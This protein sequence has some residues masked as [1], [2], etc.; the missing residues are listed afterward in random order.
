MRKGQ[1]G[2]KFRFSKAKK[3]VDQFAPYNVLDCDLTKPSYNATLF[4]FPMRLLGHKSKLSQRSHSADSIRKL[5]ESFKADAHLIL[6]FLKSVISIQ[7]LEWNPGDSKPH[8]TFRVEITDSTKD[9]VLHTRKKI[10]HRIKSGEMSIQETFTA[11]ITCCTNQ[12][13]VA[14]QK[15]TVLHHIC[16]KHPEVQRLSEQLKQLPWVGLAFPL[17][18][19]TKQAS[20]LGRIFCFLPLPPGDDEDSNTGFPVHV[21]GSFS[22]ADNRRSLKWPSEDRETDASANWNYL[23]LQHV[24]S[25]A[26]AELIKYLVANHAKE[27]DVEDRDRDAHDVY[28]AWPTLSR[29]KFRW[30][31]MVIPSFLKSLSIES[32]LWT[33]ANGGKWVDSS[34]SAVCESAWLHAESRVLQAMIDLNECVVCLPPNVWECLRNVCTDL[35]LMNPQFVRTALKRNDLYVKFNREQ[36]LHLL[37]Y[38]VK[39]AEKDTDYADLDGLKLLP[40]RNGAFTVFALKSRKVQPIFI[41]SPKCSQDL[42]PNLKDRFL[43]TSID[44][45]LNRSLSSVSCCAAVQLEL[46]KP[47]RVCEL[48]KKILPPSSEENCDGEIVAKKS[49]QPN[50]DWFDNIWKWLINQQDNWLSI[51]V[52]CHLIPFENYSKLAQIPLR[53][54][55]IFSSHPESRKISISDNL[56]HGLRKQGCFVLQNC[57]PYVYSSR[58]LLDYI[59]TPDKVLSCI[60]NSNSIS[61]KS[62]DWSQDQ[63]KELV[64]LIGKVVRSNPPD[65]KSSEALTVLPLFRSFKLAIPK[66]L[67]DCQEFAP[68]DLDVRLPLQSDLLLSPNLNEQNILEAVPPSCKYKDLSFAEVFRKAVF[69]TFEG[70][71]YSDKLF[72]IKYLLKHKDQ[73]DKEMRQQMKSLTFVSVGDG[74]LRRPD[75]VFDSKEST[76]VSLFSGKS[77]F[78][79]GD[80]ASDAPLGKDLKEVVGFR[81]VSSITAEELVAVGKEAAAGSIS[82]GRA[83]LRLFA[84]EKW[85]K[86]QLK[87]AK[88]DL[89]RLQ[90]CPVESKAPYGYPSV[91]PWKAAGKETTCQTSEIVCLPKEANVPCEILSLIVGSKARIVKADAGKEF[92]NETHLL[93]GFKVPSPDEVCEHWVEATK[94][95]GRARRSRIQFDTM[96][97]ALFSAL[98]SMI[99]HCWA[100]NAFQNAFRKYFCEGDKFLWIDSKVGFVRSSQIAKSSCFENSLEPW[101]FRVSSA[102]CS[103]LKQLTADLNIKDKFDTSDILDALLE[104]KEF[105]DQ[106]P[107]DAN[108]EDDLSLV[109][110]ILNWVVAKREDL[111]S[112]LR[113]K[114]FVPVEGPLLKLKSCEDLVYCDA[115]W[116]SSSRRELQ[117]KHSFVH[118]EI[119]PETARKL[120]VHSLSELVAKSEPLLFEPCGQHE[121]LTLRLR[122]IIDE[123]KDGLG[124]FKELIQNADDAQAKRICF[125]VDLRHGKTSSL[126]SRGMK[127]CQGPALWAYNDAAFNDEDFI[128]ITK[129]AGRTKQVQLDKIGKFG[130]GFNSVYHVTEVPS[131]VSRNYVVIFDPH[132][133]YLGADLIQDP[134]QPGIKIDFLKSQAVETFEDQFRPYDKVFGCDMKGKTPFPGTL[135]RL[136]LRTRHQAESS[137][138]KNEPC[139]A[140]QIDNAIGELKRQASEVM[141]FLNHVQSI[142]VYKLPEKARSP[143]KLV[144]QFKVTSE[145]SS[146]SGSVISQFELLKESAVVAAATEKKSRD[147]IISRNYSAIKSVTVS[148]KI[149]ETHRWLVCSAVGQNAALS[150]SQSPRGREFGAVPFAGVAAKLGESTDTPQNIRGEVFSFL[151][152][153]VASNLPFHVNGVFSVSSNRR[154]LWLHDYDKG[155]TSFG[156]EWNKVLVTDAV[157]EASLMLFRRIT[158]L[159]PKAFC[160][161]SYYGVWPSISETA[162]IWNLF[163]KEFYSAIISRDLMSTGTN[164]KKWTS[165]SEALLLS[166]HVKSL[167]YAKALTKRAKAHVYVDVPEDCSHVTDSLQAVNEPLLLQR[168]L[169]VERFVEEIVV[170]ALPSMKADNRNKLVCWILCLV[171]SD[172]LTFSERFKNLC[173]VPCSPTGK[174]F[175]PPCKLI[176]PKGLALK[177][178]LPSDGR[179]PLQGIFDSDE[180]ILALKKLGMKR[181]DALDWND[182]VERMRNGNEDSRRRRIDAIVKLMNNLLRSRKDCPPGCLAEIKVT[183]FW[184]LMRCPED[185]ALASKWR[186]KSSVVGLPGEVFYREWHLLVGS[187]API[188]T[189]SSS[190]LQERAFS[191]WELFNLTDPPLPMILDQFY[192]AL[193][194][195][196]EENSGAKLPNGFEKMIVSLYKELNRRLEQGEIDDSFVCDEV[197][198]NKRN[199]VFVQNRLVKSS[200]LA[201]HCSVKAAPY[202]H[203][204]PDNLLQIRSLLVASGVV[205]K[206]D[207]HMFTDSLIQMAEHKKE[208]HLSESEVDVC[209]QLLTRLAKE[210]EDWLRRLREESEVPLISADLKLVPA[211]QLTYR[212]VRWAK[213]LERGKSHRYVHEKHSV[214]MKIAMDLGVQLIRDRI[215]AS[216][217]GRCLGYRFGQQEPLT[218]RLKKVIETYPW[219]EQILQ[220]LVQNAEDA[221]ATV[222]HVVFDKRYHRSEEVFRDEWKA[223]QGPALLVYNDRPFTDEDI[224]GIQ[225]VGLG[226]KGNDS[227]KVGQFGIGFNAVYHLTDCPSFLS[228]NK[229]LCV[230]DPHCKFIYEATPDAPGRLFEPAKETFQLFADV[231]ECYSSVF[232]K[233]ALKKG[234]LFRF[235]LRTE[236]LA[237]ESRICQ[238]SISVEKVDNLMRLFAESAS[239]ML[240]FL[241]HLRSI[242]VSAINANGFR[243]SELFSAETTEIGTSGERAKLFDKV[244]ESKHLNTNAVKYFSVTYRLSVKFTFSFPDVSGRRKESAITW[245]VHQSVGGTGTFRNTASIGLLPRVGIAAPVT[246]TNLLRHSGKAFCFLPL[247]VTTSLPVHVNGH[248][249]LD[250]ARRYLFLESANESSVEIRQR[251]NEDIIDCAIVPAYAEFLLSARQL[252]G[253]RAEGLSETD[254]RLHFWYYKLFPNKKTAEAAESNYY[255]ARL[256]RQLY[257]H[258]EKRNLEVLAYLG[259]PLPS[260]RPRTASLDKAQSYVKKWNDHFE[261][262]PYLKWLPVG[263]KSSSGISCSFF[264]N[265]KQLE[266]RAN[267]FLPCDLYALK[268]LLFLLGMPIVAVP[269]TVFENLTAVVVNPS[270][271][272]EFLLTFNQKNPSC[273]LR[274]NE[275]S[276]TVLRTSKNVDLVLKFLLQ[277]GETIEG[278]W[279]P[280][281][282]IEQLNGVPL[283]LT[284]DQRLRIFSRDSPVFFSD[285]SRL[286]PSRC[287][288]FLHQSLRLSTFHEFDWERTSFLKRLLPSCLG[289]LLPKEFDFFVSHVGYL[290]WSPSESFRSPSSEWIASFWKYIE[291][292]VKSQ[293]LESLASLSVIPVIRQ[294]VEFL[295]PPDLSYTAF[296]FSSEESPDAVRQVL[297][298][299]GISRLDLRYIEKEA[300]HCLATFRCHMASLNH[301]SSLACALLYHFRSSNSPTPYQ[302]RKILQH[303]ESFIQKE[304]QLLGNFKKS[305][306]R[307]LPL[308]ELFSDATCVEIRDCEAVIL[309]SKLPREECWQWISRANGYVVLRKTTALKDIYS[310][311]G[312]A[313]MNLPKVYET[314]ILPAFKYLSNSTRIKHLAFIACCWKKNDL[315]WKDTLSK[316]VSTPCFDR[317]GHSNPLTVNKFFDRGKK[318]FHFM[319]TEEFFPPAIEETEELTC[320]DWRRFLKKIGLQIRSEPRQLLEFAESIQDRWAT[321]TADMAE[322]TAEIALT[323]VTHIDRNWT[324]YYSKNLSKSDTETLTSIKFLPVQNIR[325]DLNQLSVSCTHGLEPVKSTSFKQGLLFSSDNELLCWT[326]RPLFPSWKSLENLIKESET[327][328]AMS[329]YPS[330]NDVLINIRNYTKDVQRSIEELSSEKV[331]LLASITS[332]HFDHFQSFI[333]EPSPDL[334]GDEDLRDCSIFTKGCSETKKVLVEALHEQ[335]CIFIPSHKCFVVPF[336]VV[337]AAEKEI[338]PMLFR[339]PNYLFKNLLFLRHLGVEQSSQA[340]HYSRIL[341][342]IFSRTSD[343]VLD[344]T[345]LKLELS[346][347]RN[348]FLSL[349]K[350]YQ[351]EGA[352]R[353]AKLA[354]ASALDPLYLP[355]SRGKLR[356]ST[357]LVFLDR[358]E[359]K[360]K[361]RRLDCSFLMDLKE[362]DLPPLSKETVDLLPNEL[363]LTRFSDI[364]EEAVLKENLKESTNVIYCEQANAV[365]RRLSSPRFV[366]GIKSIV[367][368]EKEEMPD[369]VDRGLKLLL[370]DGLTVKCM[371]LISTCLYILENDKKRKMEETESSCEMFIEKADGKATLYISEAAFQAGDISLFSKIALKLEDLLQY[372]FQ[373][374]FAVLAI[375][376]EEEPILIASALEKFG[377]HSVD[378]ME[379]AV[380]SETVEVSVRAGK[381]VLSVHRGIIIFDFKSDFHV[382]EWVAYEKEENHFV[383]ALIHSKVYDAEDATFQKYYMVEIGEEDPIKVQ[384][385]KLYGFQRSQREESSSTTTTKESCTDLSSSYREETLDE[386]WERVL[387]LLDKIWALPKSER[388]T[389]IRRLYLHWH[390]DKSEDS[391]AEEIFKL[392]QRE[393]VRLSEEDV[394]LSGR[395]ARRSRRGRGGGGGVSDG[396]GG[397]GSSEGGGEWAE[398]FKVWNIEQ[399]LYVGRPAYNFDLPTQHH[400]PDVETGKMFLKQ[401]RADLAAAK[402]CYESARKGTERNFAIVCFLCHEA[403]EKALKSVLF[404]HVGISGDRLKRHFLYSFLHAADYTDCA[405]D[406]RR[407]TQMLEDRDYINSRYPDALGSVPAECYNEGQAAR[408]MEGAANVI[409]LLCAGSNP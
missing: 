261:D 50:K 216:L 370:N 263:R 20:D 78:P 202:L 325:S 175:Q 117:S 395:R 211:T 278:V 286:L 287:C 291:K 141:I 253:I 171:I 306:V 192:L 86:N 47:S 234:T 337:Q 68:K 347:V 311:L 93:I 356:L 196:G 300:V 317:K 151:P 153:S 148:E 106:N 2:R 256:T 122:N 44:I 64:S 67:A 386:K 203:Q 98:P 295:I 284:E 72:V 276:K 104:V 85:A 328:L 31:K 346:A 43:D 158:D 83:L 282:G 409:R 249:A 396:S 100:K 363:Q 191:V 274:L 383:Y 88:E 26:Y 125:L 331:E 334:L 372:K 179:F 38:V 76:A 403:V 330:T 358:L 4:R 40:L 371:E 226:S 112:A 140:C 136:P 71:N 342:H 16:K 177:L 378:R 394:S 169:E 246:G 12:S 57:P 365:K 348:L 236:K 129:L 113:S 39:D 144:L 366:S 315:D 329:S 312:I 63:C 231:K 201:F 405:E 381:D 110:E 51:L 149:K 155:N 238:N 3:Y 163:C 298:D 318:L 5:F 230:M 101:L 338:P 377:I 180:T 89:S 247:P 239:S 335:P 135:F 29:V 28:R 340:F 9:Q 18:P 293:S 197:Q 181:G 344:P 59:W 111:S 37:K 380:K 364:A 204:V 182:V 167:P 96:M 34:Q 210:D 121:P 316:L 75:Q 308:F 56:A 126:L 322:Q 183:P 399:E 166:S 242:R 408:A 102:S 314:F 406:I 25:P 224:E 199:W 118:P 305:D 252:I 208:K 225:Q 109:V 339:L 369:T 152:L 245:L 194:L 283:L 62:C 307:K 350:L 15:W 345:T 243:K 357:D 6:L 349:K 241:T 145:I 91:M 186:G 233:D 215:V 13:E 209:M 185:Y 375:L 299:L 19:E 58:E 232:N 143:T 1:N 134:Y 193:A 73:L 257:N 46:L 150:L 218:R 33:K 217:P 391:H 95:Y 354:L 127:E 107:K 174:S 45:A 120:G 235:P 92:D 87:T 22:V 268:V 280:S 79:T 164:P 41:S 99:E 259:R 74:Q 251:W 269:W 55:I 368:H 400:P 7:L 373:I 324:S 200:Q 138:I 131:F 97:K 132:Q 250:S 157:L 285:Y 176:E 389:A 84:T 341:E 116:L 49:R 294:G 323:L 404:C 128:N 60:A 362:C 123:Y 103:H 361:I 343:T 352:E 244:Q 82:K 319:L 227:E 387:T 332:A 90:W 21:H 142:E 48:I 374:Q 219:G 114:L 147:K 160:L 303:F 376:S 264:W 281:L 173:F 384:S 379:D 69:P 390:P 302:A 392:L 320:K 24:V 213:G 170:E 333:S 270:T 265:Q 355:D 205:E 220:E 262:P 214:T 382:E 221:K 255:W 297:T 206:F 267:V 254:N 61:S 279:T 397:V 52:G 8:V 35:R 80:Y 275:V 154:S 313:S 30:L 188:L 266:Q 162:Q 292:E 260:D 353:Y 229:K 301:P 139:D 228:G 296:Y 360:P 172:K 351:R 11:G 10:E 94:C 240:L 248:F 327:L 133:T 53:K 359:L 146:P 402:L 165:F 273:L 115:E 184:P 326:S 222:L 119:N 321:Q 212:D 81:R 161:Q 105:Y 277:S 14:K 336:K 310:W 159:L 168:T 23:L 398:S 388:M 66:S 195:G 290:Q 130:Q 187:Q 32:V 237:K 304:G 36:Q 289:D 27:D 178:F 124:I 258:L 54:N 393:I 367:I 198:L 223:L 156:A 189:F 65:E 108:P 207:R 272:C 309:S 137:K 70:M 17:R 77:V 407:F 271:V 401:A 288:L 385:L 42:F 190:E